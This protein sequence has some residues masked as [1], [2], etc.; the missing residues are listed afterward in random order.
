VLTNANAGIDTETAAVGV[1]LHSFS[2][3][4][5]NELCQPIKVIQYLTDTNEN[6]NFFTV[7]MRRT[8]YYVQH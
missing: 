5:I 6:L 3:I 1:R 4:A 7:K 2:S 8:Q